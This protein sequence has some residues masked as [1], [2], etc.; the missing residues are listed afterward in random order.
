MDFCRLNLANQK[1]DPGQSRRD[2]IR[3]CGLFLKGTGRQRPGVEAE[4]T[5]WVPM[6]QRTCVLQR[7]LL[8]IKLCFEKHPFNYGLKNTL[9]QGKKYIY[10][11]LVGG[12]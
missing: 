2:C 1:K 11:R 10:K 6:C 3:G 4:V 9:G 7:V 8:I 5:E 12:L